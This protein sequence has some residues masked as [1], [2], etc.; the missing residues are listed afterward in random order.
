[1]KRLLSKLFMADCLFR[2][3]HRIR[4][5]DSKLRQPI[6][7]QLMSC[8][9]QDHALNPQDGNDSPKRYQF[10]KTGRRMV[11]PE[12]SA[13]SMQRAT[14]VDGTASGKT[15][16]QMGRGCLHHGPKDRARLGLGGGSWMIE[17]LCR[18]RRLKNQLLVATV[19]SFVLSLRRSGTMTELDAPENEKSFHLQQDVFSPLG[20]SALR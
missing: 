12:G 13:A 7:S 20:R 2:T 4:V 9:T 18:D 15:G 17:P 8:L 16:G 10:S 3:Q 6:S 19:R 11:K 5:S 1:M 14:N